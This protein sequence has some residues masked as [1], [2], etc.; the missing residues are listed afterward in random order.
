M[1]RETSMSPGAPRMIL[2]LLAPRMATSTQESR[3][4]PFWMRTSARRS[5]SIMLG[6]TSASWKFWVPRVSESTSTRS[7]PTASASDLRS[8]IVVTTRS[9]S[10]AGTS[11]ANSATPAR[12]A[13]DNRWMRVIGPLS[14]IL[15]R[16][17]RVG[18]EDERALQEDLVHPSRTQPRL[19]Q[20][21][22]G[23]LGVLV[24]DPEL[25]E[26]R[27]DEGQIRLHGPLP[28]GI[29]R[30]LR[31]VVAHAA[32]PAPEGLYLGVG[33]PAEA[34]TRAVL[35]RRVDVV[36][37]PGVAAGE[38]TFAGERQ[39]RMEPP[40][41][42]VLVLHVQADQC[43]AELIDREA[44]GDG[45][46]DLDRAGIGQL[47]ERAHAAGDAGLGDRAA[48]E[49]DLVV[50]V[51]DTDQPFEI[52]GEVGHPRQLATSLDEPFFPEERAVHVRPIGLRQIV[53][54]ARVQ[55][56]E[57][58]AHLAHL[59]LRP[60]RQGEQR[61]VRLGETDADLLL[62]CPLAAL[63]PDLRPRIG[64][65][66][67]E[68]IELDFSRKEAVLAAGERPGPGAVDVALRE[69]GDE[70]TGDPHV[71]QE[72][73]GSPCAV[74]REGLPALEQIHGRRRRGRRLCRTR[75][76]HDDRR[77]RRHGRRLGLQTPQP[78]AERVDRLL[79]LLL[80]VLELL[81]HLLQLSAEGLGI[82][83]DRRDRDHQR[84]GE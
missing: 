44:T 83:R 8:G 59:E 66:L 14:S 64:I 51:E 46:T 63:D 56:A 1:P 72:L 70:I 20:Q 30:I 31:P 26:V 27:R 61:E 49:R 71:E 67:A 65:D 50:T 9:F 15:E 24:A 16:V 47:E 6:R 33:V 81:A 78:L 84:Q 45:G 17:R 23:A 4:R 38:D 73:T 69:V 22:M 58:V 75:R 37:H 34:S 12:S 76:L 35:H 39:E 18:A 2:G 11:V 5:L 82:L 68:E 62:G 25:E 53:L 7:P 77:R 32:G 60:P 36:A 57:A 48:A 28:P 55:E 40:L 21:R 43:A 29:E 3:S 80:G 54:M 52:E 42:P 79:I 10:A 19:R 74:Q 13:I 41:R